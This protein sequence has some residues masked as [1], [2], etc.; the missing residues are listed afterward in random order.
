MNRIEEL[1]RSSQVR[2]QERLKQKRAL[3]ELAMA[4]CT[5][6]PQISS[7]T[8]RILR[9][10][11]QFLE[12]EQD[13]RASSMTA[14]N[15]NAK[16]GVGVGGS[17]GG[18]DENRQPY[19][20]AQFI[21]NS[22]YRNYNNNNNDNANNNNNVS[23]SLALQVSERLYREAEQR[24]Q[25][26][27]WVQHQVQDVRLSQCTFQPF[28]NPTNPT[29]QQQTAAVDHR[30]PIHERLPD[31]LR[32]KK[33]YMQA[34]SEAV[35]EEVSGDLTFQPQI[36]A[37][38]KRIAEQRL[39]GYGVSSAGAAAGVGSGVGGARG[40]V[41]AGPSTGANNRYPSAASS[42]SSHRGQQGGGGG[43][44]G[45]GGGL[46]GEQEAAI[47]LGFHTDVAS[48]LLDQGRAMAKHKQ[49]LRQERDN[50]VA[51]SMERSAISK[52]SQRIVQ[53]IP[54]LNE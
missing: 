41:N 26:Q 9:Q 2:Q 24:A 33:Q 45:S 27:R 38:S 16:G 3:D 49:Q 37:R 31:M 48:R 44:G 17:A 40:G 23:S 43:G 6:R 14:C 1:H 46:S 7:G 20:N 5:F 32:E 8:D 10:K 11:A 36:D 12:L 53:K 28:I 15:A 25:Q 47:V 21:N 22:S 52:G 18:G 54:N 51:E 42:S 39:M 13:C 19:V 50:A 30:K 35:H 29:T 34:L 4:E